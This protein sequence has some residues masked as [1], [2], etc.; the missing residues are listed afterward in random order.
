MRDEERDVERL[1][2]DIAEFALARSLKIAAAESLTSGAIAAALGAAPSAGE[3]FSGSVVAYLS[4]TKYDVLGVSPGPVVT[5]KV[6][7]QMAS[8]ARR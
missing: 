1:A 8:G 6:A 5:Q 4:Q 7:L 2:S 3:W